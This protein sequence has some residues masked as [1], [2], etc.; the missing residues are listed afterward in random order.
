MRNY[1]KIDN[2]LT[3]DEHIT[4]I[5]KKANGKLNAL[6]IVAKQV[7]PEKK[8]LIMKVFF[9]AQ[10][11]YCSLIRMFDNRSLNRQVSRLHE[12][13]LR[14]VYNDNYLSYEDNL[15]PRAILK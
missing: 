14:I 15:V 3:F 4:S 9:S 1:V 2:K 12:Q 10:F 13:C 5:W 7:C 11:S 6:S 8:C